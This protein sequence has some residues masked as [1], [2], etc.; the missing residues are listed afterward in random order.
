[1]LLDYENVQPSD[2]EL[3][4]LV[5]DLGQVWVFHGPHQREVEKRFASFGTAAT[6]VPISKTGKNALDFH[7]SFY[8]GYIAS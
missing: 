1:M 3:R 8:M 6:A 4:A 7:L 5:P 2:A